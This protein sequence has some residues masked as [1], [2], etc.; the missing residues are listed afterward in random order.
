MFASEIAEGNAEAS[1]DFHSFAEAIKLQAILGMV[2]D[3]THM[4]WHTP[5][6][7][8]KCVLLHALN[9]WTR[10][11]IVHALYF[12]CAINFLYIHRLYTNK[13]SSFFPANIH[14]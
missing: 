4:P 13:C 9:G 7:V 12:A 1:Y 3:R 5:Q 8:K 14:I 2:C 11:K 10:R 6:P